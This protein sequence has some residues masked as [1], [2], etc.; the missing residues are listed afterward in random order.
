MADWGV[1]DWGMAAWGAPARGAPA[2]GAV[3]RAVVSTWCGDEGGVVARVVGGEEGG[4]QSVGDD[5]Q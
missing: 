2:P 4:R 3:A 5:E 1:A